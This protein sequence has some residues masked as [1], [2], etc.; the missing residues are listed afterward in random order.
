VSASFDLVL[1]R[2]RQARQALDVSRA[3]QAG[4][5]VVTAR[6]SAL[7]HPIGARVFDTVTGL[8]GEVVYGQRENL[9]VPAP[10]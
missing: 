9:I 2:V 4:D 1:E 3:R 5:R 7:T 8:E 10:G 6:S